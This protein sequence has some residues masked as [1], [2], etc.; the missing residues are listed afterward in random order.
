LEEFG[1]KYE[2]VEEPFEECQGSYRAV[3][4]MMMT[5]KMMRNL[6]RNIDIGAFI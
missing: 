6:S 3:E 2:R 5:T 1:I 4:P